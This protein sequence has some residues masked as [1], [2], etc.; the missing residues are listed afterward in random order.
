V[1]G[2]VKILS[3]WKALISCLSSSTHLLLTAH[4]LYEALLSIWI[5]FSFPSAMPP[6]QKRAVQS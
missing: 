6:L 3:Y 5:D 2:V 1:L 4:L